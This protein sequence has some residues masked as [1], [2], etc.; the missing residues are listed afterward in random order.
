MANHGKMKVLIIGAHPSDP[1]ANIG[2]TVANHVNRGDDVTLMTLTY[3]LEVHTEYLIGKPEEEIRR[4]VKQKAME[5][6]AIVGVED[7]RFLDFGDSPLLSTRD[8]LLEL[9][10]AIQDIRPDI[11]ISAHYPFRE[12][13]H[14]G[15]HG[16]AARMVERAPTGRYYA[17][18]E[19][20]RPK[21]IWFSATELTAFTSQVV[22]APDTFV[23]ITD[24]IE[25]KVR[26]CIT[27]WNK[28]PEDHEKLDGMFRTMAK[29]YGRAAGLEYAEV[30][31]SPWLKRN[32]VTHL[33]G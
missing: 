21:E 4:T 5:A 7:Y 1:F 19:P 16:E 26:A 30:F 31:E 8:N 13:Q 28:P 18:K 17:G 9:G 15:D 2:G 6:A 23:D 29:E 25:Q 32:A 14:G 3:G 12:T 33:G 22:R 20:H 24:T 27:T 11:V 10:E